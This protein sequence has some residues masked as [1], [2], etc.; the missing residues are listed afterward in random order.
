M[1]SVLDFQKKM[2]GPA[3]PQFFSLPEQDSIVVA[4][5]YISELMEYNKLNTESTRNLSNFN[6]QWAKTFYENDLK[7]ITFFFAFFKG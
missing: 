7:N 3:D 6:F 4:K 5:N 2:L 1:L